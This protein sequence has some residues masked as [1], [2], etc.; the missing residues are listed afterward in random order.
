MIINSFSISNYKSIRNTGKIL[1][2][3]GINLI[4]GKNNVGKTAL[5]ECL[6]L[7]HNTHPHK[8]EK[9]HPKA[10]PP[11]ISEVYMSF[12]VPVDEFLGQMSN[13][14]NP[15]WNFQIPK[16][17]GDWESKICEML[18]F[19]SGCTFELE[20]K[21]LSNSQIELKTIDYA[22]FF[23]VRDRDI[24]P[25]SISVGFNPDRSGVKRSNQGSKVNVVQG[26]ILS[27]QQNLYR[28]VAER[29]GITQGQFQDNLSLNSDATNLAG[30]LNQLS[31]TNNNQF[32]TL[33][34]WLSEIFP[35]VKGISVPTKQGSS[36]HTEI[37]V[38]IAD[39]DSGRD[40]LRI[41]LAECGTG[42]GQVLAI[43][44][45]VLTKTDPQV[46]IIDEPNTFLHPG[47]SKKLIEILKSHPQHQYIIS[48]HSPEIVRS[49][50]PQNV[51][52]LTH[53]DGETHIETI[54]PENIEHVKQ[55]LLEFGSNLSDVFGADEILWVEGPTEE[56]CFRLLLDRF[57]T[58]PLGV[59][60]RGVVNTGDF[61]RKRD[62]K[63]VWEIYK[64]LSNASAII[65]PAVGF[66]FDREGRSEN[67]IDNLFRDSKNSVQFLPRRMFENYLLDPEAVYH[68]LHDLDETVSQ[69]D[70]KDWID[71]NHLNPDYYF[72]KDINKE[73]WQEMIHGAEFLN[74]LFTGLTNQRHTFK[75]TR[76][77]IALTKYLLSEK[78]ESFREIIS[79][80]EQFLNQPN[81]KRKAAA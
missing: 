17:E 29:M 33:T 63:V 76:D 13:Q 46:I 40:D 58:F 25:H 4:L 8:T 53:N 54:D 22:K 31:S 44:F 55:V 26:V 35:N 72:S 37:F 12:S 28:F 9:L 77:N 1:L 39:P 70:V 59:S 69:A 50:N 48:T 71:N 21:K 78:P 3:P 14:A 80:L 47:A 19:G 56:E 36:T 27:I 34:S 7:Q 57:S 62:A 49:A 18:R 51:L 6:S 66:I 75:K 38:W 16:T 52:F 24:G 74:D 42:L 23:G 61:E 60:V 32:S 64:K 15:L 65:P 41:P 10:Q 45:V 67:D 68:V 11:P 43:L 2:T 79:L 5:L 20:I 73:D 81:E 30:A